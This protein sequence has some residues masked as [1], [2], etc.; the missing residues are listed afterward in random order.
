MLLASEGTSRRAAVLSTAESGTDPSLG[1]G[2]QDIKHAVTGGG[3][4]G[5][6]I[7]MGP[8]APAGCPG[9]QMSETSTT[10]AMGIRQ[11]PPPNIDPDKLDLCQSPWPPNPL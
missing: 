10:Q 7:K 4:H 6:L 3:D 9:G 2:K 11:V 8:G 1:G 5:A